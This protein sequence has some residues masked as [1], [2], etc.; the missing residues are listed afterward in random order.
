MINIVI[1]G[2]LRFTPLLFLI[3]FIV[4][5]SMFTAQDLALKKSKLIQPKE[6]KKNF[7][8]IVND[9]SFLAMEGE[10]E[11]YPISEKFYI[12]RGQGNHL[13]LDDPYISL[14]HALIYRSGQELRLKDLDS[15]NGVSLNGVKINKTTQV[16]P[17]DSIVIGQVVLGVERDDESAYGS[18]NPR[19]I[20]KATK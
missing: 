10:G 9:N 14:Q 6:E 3:L 11:R 18:Y 17:G 13:V 1:T 12:G 20:G 2:L 7:Y 15:T 19:R 5:L 16:F 4:A 8:L